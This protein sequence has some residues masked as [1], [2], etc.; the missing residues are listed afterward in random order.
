MPLGPA[1]RRPEWHLDCAEDNTEMPE[2]PDISPI[3]LQSL[4][5]ILTNTDITDKLRAIKQHRSSRAVQDGTAL[6]NSQLELARRI[7]AATDEG[8]RAEIRRALEQFADQMSKLQQF[9]AHEAM[10]RKADLDENQVRL[11]RQ[12]AAKWLARS[13]QSK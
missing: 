1:T 12:A 10:A 13:K 4:L 5:D 2:P 3:N 11:V 7:F 8:V 9:D 6:S